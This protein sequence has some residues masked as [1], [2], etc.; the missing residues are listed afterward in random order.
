MSM[1]TPFTYPVNS[2]VVEPVI[3]L[4]NEVA[5]FGEI[6]FPSELGTRIINL[7]FLDW[8]FSC[9]LLGYRH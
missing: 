6:S 3:K 7:A 1:L 4:L 5:L 9:K 8:H 2:S